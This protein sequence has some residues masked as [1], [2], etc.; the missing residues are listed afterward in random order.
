MADLN[1]LMLGSNQ[2]PARKSRLRLNRLPD[3]T[4]SESD[5]EMAFLENPDLTVEDLDQWEQD[6]QAEDLWK[7][8]QGGSGPDWFATGLRVVPSVLGT[9]IGGGIGAAGA[10]VGA[11]PGAAI[12]GGLGSAGGE[13]LAQLYERAMGQRD[14][15]SPSTVFLQAGL[16]AIP[17]YGGKALQRFSPAV[18]ALGR[19]AINTGIGAGQGAVGTVATGISERYDENGSLLDS[20]PSWEQAQEEAAQGAKFGAMFGLGGSAVG[21]ALAA[22]RRPRPTTNRNPTDIIEINRELRKAG[23]PELSDGPQTAFEGERP[24][25]DYTPDPRFAPTDATKLQPWEIEDAIGPNRRTWPPTRTP[26]DEWY[27]GIRRSLYEGPSPEPLAPPSEPPPPNDL[28]PEDLALF[29]GERPPAPDL[30]PSPLDSPAERAAFADL[31]RLLAQ[32]SNPDDIRFRYDETGAAR[33]ELTP[34]DP[35]ARMARY[36]ERKAAEEAAAAQAAADAKAARQAEFE[37]RRAAE[38]Q[39]RLDEAAA[40]E[41]TWSGGPFE[42]GTIVRPAE[43]GAWGLIPPGSQIVGSNPTTSRVLIQGVKGAS[44][45]R[46]IEVP[47]EQIAVDAPKPVFE[48][49][50]KNTR[51][52][53]PEE[54]ASLTPE[55]Q[56]RRLR[57]MT[58]EERLAFYQ[59]QQGA[60]NADPLG[61]ILGNEAVDGL[62][63][64]RAP[65]DAGVAGEV[66]PGQATESPDYGRLGSQARQDGFTGTDADL[67]AALDDLTPTAR[68][69]QAEFEAETGYRP[70][71][72]DVLEMMGVRPGNQWW[73]QDASALGFDPA[74]LDVA[75]PPPAKTPADLSELL[76]TPES[77]AAAAG[78]VANAAS[79]VP[80]VPPSLESLLEPARAI[81]EPPPVGE[82]PAKA[83]PDDVVPAGYRKKAPTKKADLGAYLAPEDKDYAFIELSKENY[84]KE[85]GAKLKA[86]GY[87]YN[88]KQQ[89]WF[90]NTIDADG[91][92]LMTPADAEA[93][94]AAI[95]ARSEP[96]PLSGEP[97][98]GP[99]PVEPAQAPGGARPLKPAG[100]VA[101]VGD[102]EFS[103]LPDGRISMVKNS[104]SGKQG[105]YVRAIT[106][107]E[108]S[109]LDAIIP[110]DLYA[111]SPARDLEGLLVPPP[112]PPA[113]P[114]PSPEVTQAQADIDALLRGELTDNLQ[115]R[116]V[117]QNTR[118]ADRRGR[119]LAQARALG[120]TPDQVRAMQEALETEGGERVAAAKAKDVRV[121]VDVPKV[122]AELPADV[123]AKLTADLPEPGVTADAPPRPAPEAPAP[124]ARRTEEGRIGWAKNKLDSILGNRVRELA[125]R[126][127]F[128]EVLPP[129]RESWKDARTN[130]PIDADYIEALDEINAA[131]Q[132]GDREALLYLSAHEQTA[133]ER[134]QNRALKKGTR[135]EAAQG[136]E[137]VEP[138][139]ETPG[140]TTLYSTPLPHVIVDKILES[141]FTN[142]DDLRYLLFHRLGYAATGGLAG[143]ASAQG[144][145]NDDRDW[146]WIL[147]GMAAGAFAPEL[148][149][150]ARLGLRSAKN[151]A[152]N[153]FEM[154]PPK[155]DKRKIEPGRT[156]PTAPKGTAEVFASKQGKDLTLL[157]DMFGTVQRNL[158]E[159]RRELDKA[160]RA[161]TAEIHNKGFKG[162]PQELDAARKRHFGSLWKKLDADAKTA[163]QMKAKFMRS[164]AADLRGD[165]TQVEEAFAGRV[166]LG[167]FKKVS[168]GITGLTYRALVGF[169]VDTA[170]QNLT[171]PILAL[172]HVPPKFLHRGFK[173]LLDESAQEVRRSTRGSAKNWRRSDVVQLDKPL[174]LT[175]EITYK[176]ARF[177]NPKLQKAAEHFQNLKEKGVD[178]MALLRG[179]DSWNRRG[180][181]LGAAEYAM[182]KGA[183]EAAAFDWAMDVVNKTQGATGMLGSNPHWRGP[184][185]QLL[186]P[187]MKYPT[188]FLEH[189]TDVLTKPGNSEGKARLLGTIAGLIGAGSLAG[190]STENLL[191]GG[192]RPL[193]LDINPMNWDKNI[194]KIAGAEAGNIFPVVRGV[195]R[196]L[197]VA[198]GRSETPVAPDLAAMV[199]GRYPIKTLDTLNEMRGAAEQGKLT[200]VHVRHTPSGTAVPHTLPEDLMSLLGLKSTRQVELQR[201]YDSLQGDYARDT[202]RQ[203]RTVGTVKQ[204]VFKALD[205]GDVKEARRLSMQLT[206]RQRRALWSGKNRTRFQKLLSGMDPKTRKEYEDAYGA[207]VRELEMR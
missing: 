6:N 104:K 57:M 175:E 31:E 112:E 20:L 182:S 204:D 127:D 27:G 106:P 17:G 41:Q 68:E 161:F 125:A 97:A 12:G 199:F 128:G 3:G 101:T 54:W 39:S 169:G 187:F 34:Q 152:G 5:L 194:S 110:E 116:T 16:G 123:R 192:A 178:P 23:L 179:T 122:G 151:A 94:A 109:N 140:G 198:T 172:S 63:N 139:R 28:S 95:L 197:E 150:L 180:V 205:A 48:P 87:R 108:S 119:L 30:P 120:A 107:G 83:A 186:R 132:K 105:T 47:N 160:Q 33:S 40:Y 156:P 98:A 102:F 42:R 189:M 35:R 53:T 90:K 174:D 32:G 202:A 155:P 37:Q 184:V 158:P 159:Y 56:N 75:A 84:T 173:M 50:V 181:F 11:V 22:A 49:P 18:Q 81:P 59:Q 45:A 96:A 25:A 43:P 86:A 15:F 91:N 190:I 157:E 137:F 177:K 24:P 36:Q 44:E 29:G 52:M 38:E 100:T 191:I 82:G 206:K 72:N 115:R 10:G 66:R 144:D 60:T 114:P 154:Q 55:D 58:G 51:D 77:S 165:M 143:F 126:G 2:P 188:L 80:P 111:T 85:L 61:A 162:T 135:G 21:E 26:A 196:G 78:P 136:D 62:G 4:I 71:L 113:P 46:Y 148:K 153:I 141:L 207:K 88:G 89:R 147:S 185:A 183:N 171:Q 7:Q 99:P 195:K 133:A 129:A 176:G 70:P 8:Q 163:P 79:D 121:N 201:V 193:G 166:P 9:Y 164:L 1:D 13:V 73:I 67:Q 117:E 76:G 138:P 149:N 167:T 131:A 92:V 69:W 103:V 203:K 130:V 14:S 168:R 142:K 134:W 170:A 200:G 93:E 74:D 118:A 146:A 19:T 124:L 145:P 65:G 64:P